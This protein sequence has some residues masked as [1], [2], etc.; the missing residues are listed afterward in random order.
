MLHDQREY[1]KGGNPRAPSMN[2]YL[3]W[4]VKAWN[5]IP[6]EAIA[7]SFKVC[8]ITNAPDG[9]EDHLI[10]CFKQDGPVPVGLERLK[11]ARIEKRA[12]ELIEQIDLDQDEENGF[13]ND[14]SL[15]IDE[16]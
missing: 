3:N 6:K 9:S 16:E 12:I 7:D 13:I 10:H 11:L 2:V 1:T 15:V 8:G 5:N 4:I 14:T